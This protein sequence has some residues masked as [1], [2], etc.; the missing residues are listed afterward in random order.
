MPKV[1]LFTV[2]LG[3]GLAATAAS[4]A[5]AKW[6]NTVPPQAGTTQTARQ[7]AAVALNVPVGGQMFEAPAAGVLQPSAVAPAV[8]AAAPPRLPQQTVGAGL[9]GEERQAIAMHTVKEAIR[10]WV[11]AGNRLTMRAAI[12]PFGGDVHNPITGTGPIDIYVKQ[13]PPQ[14]GALGRLVGTFRKYSNRKFTVNVD[15]NGHATILGI[16]SLAP[17]Y[18]LA[19]WAATRLPMAQ[20]TSDVLH[21]DRLQEG[22]WTTLLGGGMAMALPTP[23]SW[24]VAAAAFYR[25]G[26]VI[27]KG[28]K[29]QDTARSTAFDKTVKW[30]AEMGQQA[31]YYPELAETYRFY[32]GALADDSPGTRPVSVTAFADRLAISGL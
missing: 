18:R 26:N 24:P 28:I 16:D 32:R 5:S 9:S 27:T 13:A 22:L 7:N 19:S 30:A 17:Q 10:A 4:P 31:G 11:P 29:E 3:T 6:I 8:A 2:A 1:T 12:V 25:A 21:N 15:R 20:L 23:I 14:Q